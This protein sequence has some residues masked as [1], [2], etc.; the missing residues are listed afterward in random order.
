MVKRGNQILAL[1]TLV[2]IGVAAALAP[3]PIHQVHLPVVYNEHDPLWEMGRGIAWQSGGWRS[4]DETDILK[5]YYHYSASS[6][7]I[8]TPR[9]IPI[10][11]I[12]NYKDVFMYLPAPYSGILIVGNEQDRWDQDALTEA[13]AL[14]FLSMVR[15]HYPFAKLVG[16]NHSNDLGSG[17]LANFFSLM[18]KDPYWRHSFHIYGGY[19]LDMSSRVD[20][21]CMIVVNSGHECK[22]IWITEMGYEYDQ[23]N[24]YGEMK[25]R[26]SELEADPRVEVYFGFTNREEREDWYFDMLPDGENL[27]PI[28]R[29]WIQ[30]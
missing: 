29:G 12:S 5:A 17:W 15:Q 2:M 27:S 20:R 25:R 9:E 19:G 11:R 23:F 13:E 22:T 10:I 3:T 21:F 8:H 28:G 18:G 7:Y 16:P 30:Q 6:F 1:L 4:E 26:V 14:A 24:P